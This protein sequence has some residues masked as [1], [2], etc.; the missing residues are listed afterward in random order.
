LLLEQL[1]KSRNRF[2]VQ[3]TPLSEAVSKL[4]AKLIDR[5]LEDC[6]GTRV[7]T[8]NHTD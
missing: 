4:S 8:A 5:L 1:I 6:G 2:G 7:A 3:F